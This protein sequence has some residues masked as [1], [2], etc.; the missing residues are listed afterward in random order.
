MTNETHDLDCD[1]P[2]G[3][4]SPLDRYASVFQKNNLHDVNDEDDFKKIKQRSWKEHAEQYTELLTNYVENSKK[5]LRAKRMQKVCFFWVSVVILLITVIASV[6]IIYR[7]S[8][9]DS[10]TI[11]KILNIIPPLLTFL[12]PLFVIPNLIAKYLFD[13]KE[14]E[15]MIEI[16]KQII[17]HD[18]HS[19]DGSK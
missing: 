19:M 5:T 2:S 13:T 15:H 1:A 10:E 9:G 12:T 7:V 4:E 11:D 14:E 17:N 16:V 18:D 3:I 8:T 6:L